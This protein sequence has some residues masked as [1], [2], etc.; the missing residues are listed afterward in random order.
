MP[1]HLGLIKANITLSYMRQAEKPTS[2]IYWS[3]LQAGLVLRG[4]RGPVGPADHDPEYF[5]ILGLGTG[6][7][8]AQYFNY[9]LGALGP[10][11]GRGINFFKRVDDALIV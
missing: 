11:H 4:A 9:L 8:I 3:E 5:V 2:F 6:T 7:D 1:V 10:G